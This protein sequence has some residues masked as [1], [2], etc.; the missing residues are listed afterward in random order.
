MATICK[1]LTLSLNTLKLFEA[2]DSL[3]GSMAPR[4][5]QLSLPRLALSQSQEVEVTWEVFSS[6]SSQSTGSRAPSV[7][8]YRGDPTVLESRPFGSDQGQPALGSFLLPGR[9][10]I[11]CL[12]Q[13]SGHLAW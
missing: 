3:Q 4:L 11:N 7:R 13:L 12:C 5:D 8:M 10:S 2:A 1:E 9:V 6:E